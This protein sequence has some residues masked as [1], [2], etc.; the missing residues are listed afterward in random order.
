MASLRPL[1]A[2]PTGRPRGEGFTSCNACGRAARNELLTYDGAHEGNYCTSDSEYALQ[3]LRTKEHRDLMA[4]N[5]LP[6]DEVGRARHGL[7]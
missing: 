7:G 1:A 2:L 3:R 5:P 4:G 6:L